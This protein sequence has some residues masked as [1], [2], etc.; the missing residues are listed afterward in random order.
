MT[1]L[2]SSISLLV[3]NGNFTPTKQCSSD[4]GHSIRIIINPGMIFSFSNNLDVGYLFFFLQLLNY[5]EISVYTLTLKFTFE[6]YIAL[7]I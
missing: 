5:I 4:T 7:G 3:T 6:F 2:R 1:N